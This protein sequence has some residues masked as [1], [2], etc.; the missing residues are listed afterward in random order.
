MAKKYFVTMNSHLVSEPGIS[1]S[2]GSWLYEMDGKEV[3][4]LVKKH[5][6]SF[7]ILT[8]EEYEA[9]KKMISSSGSVIESASTPPPNAPPA[10]EEVKAEE[11]DVLK[12]SK[13]KAPEAPKQKKGKS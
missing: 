3:D 13:V 10:E 8:K 12:V 7:T 9:E 11:E 6:G 1:A 2:R 4:E 5:P